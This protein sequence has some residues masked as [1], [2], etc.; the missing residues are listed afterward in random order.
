SLLKF[1]P[2]AEPILRPRDD[3]KGAP[4]S[5]VESSS[6][7]P[8]A[9]NDPASVACAGGPTDEEWEVAVDAQTAACGG[10]LELSWTRAD[11]TTCPMVIKIPPGLADGK[12]LQLTGLGVAGADVYVRLRIRGGPG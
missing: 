2:H 9:T 10:R 3:G 6:D 8:P 11:G 5:A 1:I 4:F 7:E 12:R